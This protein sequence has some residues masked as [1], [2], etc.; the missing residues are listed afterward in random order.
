MTEPRREV[1][2]PGDPDF[3]DDA[4]D[5]D[6]RPDLDA[7]DA[8]TPVEP[9]ALHVA[10][11]AVAAEIPAS[12]VDDLWIFAPR[13]SAGV[14]TGV[15]VLA[16]FADAPTDPAPVGPPRDP[17]ARRRILT[18]QYTAERDRRGRLHVRHALVEHGAAAPGR[19]PRVIEGVLRRM[20]ESLPA[21]PPRHEHIEGDPIRWAALLEVL[22]TRPIAVARERD[23]RYQ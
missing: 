16:L 20:D 1:R 18:A 14:E 15:L 2:G 3:A 7:V 8:A 5:D 22:R 10:L 23:F 12:A 11:E 21:Q 6:V 13:R 9:P 17:N 19:M 4:P